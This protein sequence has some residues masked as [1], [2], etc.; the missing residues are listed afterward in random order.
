MTHEQ[1]IGVWKLLSYEFRLADGILIRPMGQGVRGMLIYDARGWM[2]LQVSDPDRAPFA[3]GDWLLGTPAEIQAAWE[4]SFAYFGTFELDAPRGMITH[5]ITGATFP[6]W[7]G[8]HR[9]LF[10]E[11]ADNRL[12]LMTPPMPLSGEHAVGYLK[13]ERV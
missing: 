5:H 3:S 2:M 12:T 6:N 11:C 4:G 10:V 8:I 13:W 7:I 1:L 9:E